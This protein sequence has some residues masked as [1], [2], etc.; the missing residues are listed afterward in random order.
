MKDLLSVG[1]VLSRSDMK[2]IMAG[3]AGCYEQCTDIWMAC[4]AAAQS[5]GLLS[6]AGRTMIE[7]CDEQA[8]NCYGTCHPEGGAGMQLF[9]DRL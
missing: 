4:T 7:V 8:G 6:P 2:E 1:Q 5:I 3:T 9:M